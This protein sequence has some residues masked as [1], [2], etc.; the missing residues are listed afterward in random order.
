MEMYYTNYSSAKSCSMY[1][2]QNIEE[3]ENGRVQIYASL[4]SG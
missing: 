2:V 3:L 4:I 1:T